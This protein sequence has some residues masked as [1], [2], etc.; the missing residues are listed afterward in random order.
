M[1]REALL[2]GWFKKALLFWVVDLGGC[3]IYKD[4]VEF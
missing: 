2:L 4:G 1:V 3:V